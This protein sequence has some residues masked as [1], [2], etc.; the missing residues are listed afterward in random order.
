MQYVEGLPDLDKW[1]GDKKWLL[2]IEDLMAEADDCVTELLTKGS[3]H[4]NLSV[5]YL[6]QN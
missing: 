3:H 2:V 1:I 4:G 5:M 6:I